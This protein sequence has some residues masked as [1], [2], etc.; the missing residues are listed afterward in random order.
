VLGVA[1]V[2]RLWGIGFGL[3]YADAR[4]DETA[5]A[6]P[7]VSFLSG[8]LSPGRYFYPALQMY[9]LALIYL[10]YYRVSK[11][12]AGYATLAAF[13][14]SRRQSL[15]PFFYLSRGLSA[16]MGTLTIWW[17]YAIGRRVFG[18]TVGLV[19]ALFLALSF[20]HVRDSHFGVTDVP[21]T[22]LIVL[23]VLAILRWHETGRLRD[24]A[25]AGLAGGLA[26]S[27]KYN[28]LGL[29]VP[30]G[31]AVAQ[32]WIE[33]RRP[34][35]DETRALL[36]SIAAFGLVF[37]LAFLGGSPYT[38]IEWNQFVL[39]TSA[40]GDTLVRG[41]GLVLSRGWWHHARVTL[42]AA[43]GWPVYLC[44]V[45]GVAGLLVTR[46]RRSAILLSFP[47]AYYV[48]AGEG[49]TVFARYMI[50]V[51]P[52]LAIAAAWAVVTM[53]RAAV[54]A[55]RTRMRHAVLTASV[56]ALI[57]PS[58]AR[59][60]AVDRLLTRTDNRVLVAR[61]LRDLIPP[62]DSF[63][64]SDR[65]YGRA[66]LEIDGRRLEVGLVPFD[67]ANGFVEGLPD[68]ILLQRSP[69]A[70]YTQDPTPEMERLLRDEYSLVRTFDAHT[71]RTDRVYDAQDAFFLPLA[72]FRGID[73]PGPNFELYRR[74]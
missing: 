19:A 34:N 56:V 33:T 50:P 5:I 25:L 36:G 9:V 44:S 49:M 7:A 54:P 16:L 27:T 68:W 70:L 13:A 23:T 3:P 51:L 12:F 8:N 71:A 46:F 14:E 47:I 6:G 26:T 60:V 20:L 61:A 41:H 10:A 2:V 67:E 24:A 59:V 35:A 66:P 1:A 58:A 38:L 22:G 63:F 48:V 32:R 15:A 45:A 28:G 39:D 65:S 4:P 74:R 21:M 29:W 72:G 17:V 69:L 18:R 30:F 62:G 37:A 55:G 57:A 31:V 42:P 40:Q 52:F 64:Q 53:V 11:P 73:R 43:L